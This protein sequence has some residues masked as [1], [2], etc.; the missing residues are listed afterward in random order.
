MKRNIL[1]PFVY[2]GAITIELSGSFPCHPPLPSFA[3]INR[4][5]KCNSINGNALAVSNKSRQC[6]TKA[7]LK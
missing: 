3:A 5:L 7:A 4:C 2:K 6:C 1:S